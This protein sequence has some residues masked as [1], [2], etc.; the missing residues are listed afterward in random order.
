MVSHDVYQNSRTL[1]FLKVTENEDMASV[2]SVLNFV[3]ITVDVM[4]NGVPN[5]TSPLWKWCREA[6]VPCGPGREIGG[7]ESHFA[8]R[9]LLLLAAKD[10]EQCGNGES[11]AR[12]ISMLREIGLSP[13]PSRL[14]ERPEELNYYLAM[15]PTKSADD[16]LSVPVD[17]AYFATRMPTKQS[18]RLIKQWEHHIHN[19]IYL[20]Q[21]TKA[22]ET[23]MEVEQE[24]DAETTRSHMEDSNPSDGSLRVRD[25]N[26]PQ[27]SPEYFE[28]LIDNLVD[29][30][31]EGL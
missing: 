7:N 29:T 27:E 12:M 4:H 19:Q 26:N 20:N 2:I 30:L 23:A 6:G 14:R 24:E 18:L 10:Q 1:H 5:G 15:H 11:Q 22:Q 21:R 8:L 25:L 31:M 3:D 17:M 9:A 13:I 28:K 16:D